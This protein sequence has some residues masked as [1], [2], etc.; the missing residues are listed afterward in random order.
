MPEPLLQPLSIEVP[1]TILL[2]EK[3]EEL[4][5]LG[6]DVALFG[7][8]KL[9]VNAVPKVF[10]ESQVDLEKLLNITLHKSPLS[11]DMILDELY[12]MQACKASIKAGQKLSLPEMQRLVEDGFSHI[13]GMFVCQ[14]G[15][16][17]FIKMTKKDVDGLFDR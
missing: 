15:R 8:N 5:Q 10:V 17:F 11:F 12:A 7:E 1:R 3:I 16:P 6:F 2:D 4:T 13:D 9:I 14:H